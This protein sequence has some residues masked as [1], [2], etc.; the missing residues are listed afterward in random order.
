M[1][2]ILIINQIAKKLNINLT[3]IKGI[4]GDYSCYKLNENKQV[5]ELCLRRCVKNP[6]VIQKE[7]VALKE[8][9]TLDLANNALED[10]SALKVLSQIRELYLKENEICDI[11]PLEHLNKLVALHLQCNLISDISCLKNLKDLEF[12][13]LYKNNISDLS[14]IRNLKKLR[15][16]A[17]QNNPIKKVPYW[18]TDFGLDVGWEE[19]GSTDFITFYDNPLVIPPSEIIRQGNISIINYFEQFKNETDYLYEAKL[20]LV[21]EERSGKSTIVDALTKNDYKIDHHR[22]STHGIEVSKWIIDKNKV[23]TPKHFQFNIWDFGGQELYHSTHQFFLT[24][25]SLYLFVTEARK[26]LRYDDFYYWLNIINT[27][28][29]DSPVILVQ[30]KTDQDHKHKNIDEYRK[31]YPQIAV[32]LQRISC[33]SDHKDWGSIYNYNLEILKSNIFKILEEK[34]LQG[35]GDKLPKS[36]V[37]IRNEITNLH[38]T[39]LNYISQSTY[40]AICE[41]YGLDRNQALLLSDYF[42]DLG[43]FLHFRNDIQLCDTIFINHEWVTKAIYNVFDNNK[44]KDQHGKF[45]DQDLMEIWSESKYID[46]QSHLL[47]LMKNTQF[48]I[49]YQHKNKYYIA[50][51]LFNDKPLEYE[52]RSVGK[53]VL[54]RYQYEFMP[55]G[56]LSQVIVLLHKY[57]YEETYWL[58]G[59][60]FTHKNTRAL[61]TEDRFGIQNLICIKI[62]GEYIHELLTIIA[63]SIEEI[64]SSYT[65]LKIIEKY[66]CC[67]SECSLSTTPY[68]Y[69]SDTI[70]R[71]IRKGKLSIECQF[72]FEEVNISTLLGRFLPW[73]QIQHHINDPNFYLNKSI[74]KILSDTEILKELQQEFL[75]S[76]EKQFQYLVNQPKNISDFALINES[77]LEIKNHLSIEV[78]DEI[79]NFIS[80]AFIEFDKETDRKLL[81]IFEKMKDVDDWQTK[82]KLGIPLLNLVGVNI[83]SEFN[84][85]KYIK[86]I[87]GK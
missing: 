77:I 24:K 69:K 64:N 7:L 51:Q 57:I 29:G 54:F 33:N 44:I 49:C 65:N 84:L 36:W 27:L 58:H 11:S 40:F 41:K 75:Y 71:A 83:E 13:W 56:I 81:N 12:L 8:L 85:S 68:F 82:I 20:I 31:L 22:N 10:I 67:C 4:R 5:I 66:G 38:D 37:D 35:I 18:I 1:N 52:W 47:N 21:G 55:K 76:F 23:N 79:I 53:N 46:K 6:I 78:V 74:D 61:V 87:I 50:P 73:E 48:K 2:N 80:K 59:V 63:L 26:D 72:S 62:E 16:V 25:R 60:L 19:Y 17:L 86:S 15:S 39:G 43:V 42:H 34:K 3:E 28:A 45:T 70:N 30:N 14:A 32:D 9:K